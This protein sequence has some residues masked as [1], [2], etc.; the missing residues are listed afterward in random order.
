MPTELELFGGA[1]TAPFSLT[2]LLVNLAIGFVM[3][4]VVRWHFLRFGSTLSNKI[5]RAHV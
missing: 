1:G 2:E 5:G 3:A 4:L